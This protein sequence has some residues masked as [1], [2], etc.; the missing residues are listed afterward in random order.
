MKDK[1]K[2]YKSSFTAMYSA[3]TPHRQRCSM[4]LVYVGEEE[5]IVCLHGIGFGIDE[6]LQGLALAI[7]MGATKRDF[8]NTVAIHPTAG[9]VFAT[10]R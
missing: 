6:I 7:I 2:A 4:K 8:D 1:V 10:M 9:E 3:L 5:K